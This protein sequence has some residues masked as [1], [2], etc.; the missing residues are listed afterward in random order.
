MSPRWFSR[1]ARQ[2]WDGCLGR[3]GRYRRT[4]ESLTS[5]AVPADDGGRLDENEGPAPS[6][7]DAPE[8][9]PED[10]VRVLQ[11]HHCLLS[12]KDHQLPSE[13]QVLERQVPPTPQ[14]RYEGPYRHPDPIPYRHPLSPSPQEP[15]NLGADEV[16][17]PT[18]SPRDVGSPAPVGVG[19]YT[20]RDTS[21]SP[22]QS[23]PRI[24][25]SSDGPARFLQYV[26][27]I[28]RRIK[29]DPRGHASSSRPCCW[30]WAVGWGYARRRNWRL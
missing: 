27:C 11:A 21:D 15:S 30:C 29:E 22:H 3:G 10:S 1:D 26:S 19:D 20:G 13:G 18:G 17:A 28:P 12:L 2:F 4:V 24:T 23:S 6:G 14:R 8:P 9:Y 25:S 5:I 16:F 7:P